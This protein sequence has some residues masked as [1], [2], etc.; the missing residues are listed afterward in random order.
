M[1]Q[2][3]RY[4]HSHRI[5]A[6]HLTAAEI[7]TAAT[8]AARHSSHP[9]GEIVDEHP[10]IIPFRGRQSHIYAIITER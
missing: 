5:A 9:T 10:C 8:K 6:A 7:L 3:L 1:I 4:V 2:F